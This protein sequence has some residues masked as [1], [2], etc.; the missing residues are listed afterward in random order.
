MLNSQ[1]GQGYR[2]SFNPALPHFIKITKRKHTC[3][4]GE[5]IKN[6]IKK[7]QGTDGG[8]AGSGLVKEHLLLIIKLFTVREAQKDR[9]INF[10]PSCC[11]I[12]QCGRLMG[13][14]SPF[15]LPW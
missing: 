15:R 11:L 3:V 4:K 6:K 8:D 10:S 2:T 1:N 13:H 9:T 12:T 7:E 14:V 5:K